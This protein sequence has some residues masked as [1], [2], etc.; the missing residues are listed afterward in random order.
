VH[1]VKHVLYRYFPK[2]EDHKWWSLYIQVNNGTSRHTGPVTLPLLN[3][4]L[5]RIIGGQW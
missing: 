2:T 4:Q 1:K 3:L 5:T